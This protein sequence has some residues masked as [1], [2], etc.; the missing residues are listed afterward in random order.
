MYNRCRNPS[1][2]EIE[3]KLQQYIASVTVHR[4]GNEFLRSWVVFSSFGTRVMSRSLLNLLIG[5]FAIILIAFS[6]VE[7]GW[8][9]CMDGVT[10]VLDVPTSRT[11]VTN[12]TISIVPRA[13]SGDLHPTSY[14]SVTMRGFQE[15][16]RPGIQ[17]Y[18]R[19]STFPITGDEGALV[20]PYP[21]I[22]IEDL[23]CDYQV[24]MIWYYEGVELQTLEIKAKHP[25]H[26]LY[27]LSVNITISTE[28]KLIPEHYSVTQNQTYF[29]RYQY[30][31][32]R[33]L[34][35]LWNPLSKFRP[36]LDK[37]HYAKF[38]Y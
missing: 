13:P 19:A 6:T 10:R 5:S 2:I 34:I 21:A 28:E 29:A 11:S 7:C 22:L 9:P 33:D 32:I 8:V 25:Q 23:L 18:E 14:V 12:F 4:T 35:P 31:S 30:V 24:P 1:N 38:H 16:L 3:A 17:C 27:S 20:Q 15:L 37:I 36:F 26:P